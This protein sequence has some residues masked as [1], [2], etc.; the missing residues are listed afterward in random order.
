MPYA[1]CPIPYA[2]YQIVPHVT[3]KGY[4]LSNCNWFVVRTEVRANFMRNLV[5]TTNLFYCSRFYPRKSPK[6]LNANCGKANI[7]RHRQGS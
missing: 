3:E 2:L 5:L 4:I 7:L 6:A 1:L